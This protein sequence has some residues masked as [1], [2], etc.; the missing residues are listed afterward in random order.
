MGPILLKFLSRH[1]TTSSSPFPSPSV[2][3]VI[4]IVKLIKQDYHHLGHKNKGIWHAT[5]LLRSRTST[6]FVTKCEYILGREKRKK[7]TANRIHRNI[8]YSF[9]RTFII[10]YRLCDD[11]SMNF[12]DTLLLQKSHKSVFWQNIL[13]NVSSPR[14]WR[15]WSK[16]V[17][18]RTSINYSYGEDR[19][20][21]VLCFADDWLEVNWIVFLLMVTVNS[22]T[23][24]LR[25]RS[26]Q[27]QWLIFSNYWR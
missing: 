9:K 15:L 17:F 8:T 16:H 4:V 13:G 7:T 20:K 24:W 27:R 10:I 21:N 22:E 5:H 26:W 19:G 11:R 1:E 3:V 23:C 6:V 18:L 2:T 12:Y 25:D 14:N